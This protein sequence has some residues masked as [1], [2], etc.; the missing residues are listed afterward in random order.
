MVPG[1]L[2]SIVS[3]PSVHMAMAAACILLPAKSTAQAACTGVGVNRWAVKTMAPASGAEAR[4]IDPKAFGALPAPPDFRKKTRQL[5]TR[6]TGAIGPNLH[7]GDLVRVAGWVQF[8]KTSADDCDYHIQIT[9]K[10]G[11]KAGSIIVEIP[12]PD[13]RHVADPALRAKLL[14]ARAALHQQLHLTGEPPAKGLRFPD[15]VYL[16]LVGALFFDGNDYP[17]CD[18]RGKGTGAVTCWEIHPVIS[19]RVLPPPT[20]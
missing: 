6:Y 9:P 2:F 5:G 11:G 7:E 1:L 18:A 3:R 19:S 14:A 10:R 15:P 4:A 17:Q 16:E 20:N 13:A 12:Q 8:I